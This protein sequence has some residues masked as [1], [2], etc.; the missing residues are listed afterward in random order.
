MKASDQD[1]ARAVTFLESQ[2]D[3]RVLRRVPD[4]P[5]GQLVPREGLAKVVILDTET[6]GLS[7]RDD[8]LIEIGAIARYLDTRT[9]CWVGDA[10]MRSWLEDPGFPLEPYT[11]ALTGLTDGDLKGRR[12][13][14]AEIAGFLR[15]AALVIAHSAGFD[16][17]FFEQRFPALND[18]AWGCSL[19]QINWNEA[20]AGSR[21]LEFLAYK[22]GRF[23][24]AHRALP[25]CQALSYVLEHFKLPSGQT[26]LQRLV[27]CADT[28]SVRIQANGA[29][30]EKKDALKAAGYHW[31]G[32]NK[33]WHCTV[34]EEA[35][36]AEFDWLRREIYGGRPARVSVE[37]VSARA[38]FSMNPLE[39]S[40]TSEIRSVG[41]QG[42]SASTGSS[43][44]A[45]FG[46][47]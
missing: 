12:F 43:R 14:E 21:K 28:Q 16:R 30:F 7:Y 39:G 33:V 46:R 41:A 1:N 34:D 27:S 11:V 45:R 17:P 42:E 44:S 19:S 40:V 13:D 32:E 8:K 29:A 35:M 4:L 47:F 36:D 10:E 5:I 18:F 37:F 22:L 6:T 24:D 15:G 26:A 9:G 20:G 38:R 23:Y 3:F 25:D 31:D 2:G